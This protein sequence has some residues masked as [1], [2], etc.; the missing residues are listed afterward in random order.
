MQIISSMS[1]E[2][3]SSKQ[4]LKYLFVC[5]VVLNE[6]SYFAQCQAE[7]N[8]ANAKNNTLFAC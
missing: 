5:S 6:Q 7:N 2:Q 4:A 3:I 1:H 8:S